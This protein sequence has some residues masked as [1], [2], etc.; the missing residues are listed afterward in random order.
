MKANPCHEFGKPLVVEDMGIDPPRAGE[1]KAGLAAF[2]MALVAFAGSFQ[3]TA[4]AAEAEAVWAVV[5]ADDNDAKT[6]RMQQTLFADQTVKGEQKRLG[7]VLGL[8]VLYAGEEA[9]RP[10][11]VMKLPLGVDLRPG[12]VLRVDNYKEIKAPYLRCTNAG[13]EVQVELTAELVAQLKNGLNLRVGFRPFGSSKTVA[14]DA[15]LKGFTR[16]FNR[17]M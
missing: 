15:S 5:C 7:K 2:A 12:M 13:C 4:R 14:I 1:L 11:L 9:R 8:A 17:L 6:C 3:G 10:L 16:A